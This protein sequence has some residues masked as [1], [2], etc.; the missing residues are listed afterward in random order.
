MVQSFY[1]GYSGVKTQQFGVDAWS[2]NIA[3]INTNGY[4]ADTPRFENIFTT[5]MEGV[6]ASSPINNTNGY[7]VTVSSNGIDTSMGSLINAN[8]SDFNMALGSNRGWFVVGSGGNEFYTRSGAFTRDASGSIVNP[9][10]QYL[11]GVDLGKIANN[12]ITPSSNPT[13]DINTLKS[14]SSL[15][16]LKVPED[17]RYPPKETSFVNSAIN[18]NPKSSLKSTTSET[19][20]SSNLNTIYGSDS[21]RVK[22][23]AE[24]IVINQ[25]DP[26]TGTKTPTTIDLTGLNT[27]QDL[28]DN[29]N[30]LIEM[31]GTSLKFVNATG[32]G[33]S[34]EIDFNASSQNT[35]KALGIT[36][37]E[38][39]V[40][41]GSFKSSE[42]KIPQSTFY[43]KVYDAQGNEYNLKSEY[44][45]TDKTNNE[46]LW[47]VKSGIY[48]TAGN[49]ISDVTDGFMKFSGSDA[50]NIPILLASN[51]TSEVNSFTINGFN[52]KSITY[53]PKEFTDEF[54][55]KYNST[56]VYSFSETLTKYSDGSGE[57]FLSD[58]VIDGNGIIS[59]S[60]D[61][62]KSEIF[63]RVGI[64]NFQNPQGL[65]KMGG[66]LFK[67][68]ENSGEALLNWNTDG[69]LK[70]T[71]VI[72]GKLETSNVKMDTALT[73]LMIMQRAYSASTKSIST[74]D[75]M[76]KEAIGL[77][78]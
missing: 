24:Q 28:I 69:V 16:P 57:G 43:E 11:Y 54:G 20:L 19:L 59:V 37:S 50:N 56:N 10:G 23:S 34:L 65:A 15:S 7:G 8:D 17:L 61:N 18:L 72:Q 36:S 76:V 22:S 55:D 39:I 63:G 12:S 75:D 67:A 40:E 49:L 3:N 77:K 30:G 52:G 62:G 1:N 48:D 31:D 27:L 33:S 64:T 35:L 58:V 42:L 74:A 44:T 78:R 53:N 45:L 29:S 4:R 60:F 6:N 2:N 68:T 71:S 13:A 51:G 32:S 9:D 46:E 41:G 47:S 38:T 5:A 70:S 21:I 66:N 73:Q 14:A 25:I 26:A